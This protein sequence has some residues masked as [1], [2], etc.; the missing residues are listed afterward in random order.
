MEISRAGA[1]VHALLAKGDFSFDV[2]A[3]ALPPFDT[4][5]LGQILPL[6]PHRKT[7]PLPSDP[8]AEGRLVLLAR[9]GERLAG[10]MV[11]SRRWNG[12]AG[13]DDLAVE[14]GFRRRG[15]AR[16]LLDEA[17]GWARAEALAG[18]FAETQTN[19]IDACR[20]YEAS[21]FVLAGSDRLLYA[22]TAHRTETAL[23]WYKL[24]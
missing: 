23:F 15:V 16:R 10:F 19:N 14:R 11:L 1:D 7:Y 18:L 22:A 9:E 21:G 4:G 8:G 2:T 20:F 12:L 5:R 17:A 24:F 6:P 13:I 3:E